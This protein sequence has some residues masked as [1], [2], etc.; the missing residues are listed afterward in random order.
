MSE[1]S[2]SSVF[3]CSFFFFSSRRRHTRYIGDWSSDVCSSDLVDSVLRW[4]R[5]AGLRMLGRAGRGRLGCLLHVSVTGAYGVHHVYLIGR[6]RRF[7]NLFF[8]APKRLRST[9]RQI[10][11][12]RG[13]LMKRLALWLLPM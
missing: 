11:G 12:Q 3:M 1:V 10:C 6:L 8:G 5:L 7:L 4:R 9:P 13:G 2:L